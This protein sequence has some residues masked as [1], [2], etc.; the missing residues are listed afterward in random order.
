[1]ITGSV[2]CR[3]QDIEDYSDYHIE[4]FHKLL[5]SNKQA[6]AIFKKYNFV[7]GYSNFTF[8]VWIISH[9]S[10]VNLV[11][12]RSLYYKQI[13]SAYGKNFVDNKEYKHKKNFTSIL[14]TLSL[15]DVIKK[16]LPEC[17]RFKSVNRQNN[18]QLERSMY[19]FKYML[20]NPDTTLDDFVE[21]ILHNAG[22]V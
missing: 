17:K 13:N 9:K 12:D 19:G 10:Q 2:F 21:L 15:D 3:V 1:M 4:K 14:E 20:S 11:T 8:E 22:L 5:E 18:P 16:A 7:I 6:K